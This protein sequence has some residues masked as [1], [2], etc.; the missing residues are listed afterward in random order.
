VI[1]EGKM[2]EVHVRVGVPEDFPALMVLAEEVAKENGVA[3]PDFDKVAAEMWASLHQDLG[4]VGVVGEPGGRLEAFVLLII[5]Q[6]WYSADPI[7]E[8]R[9]VFVSKDYRSAKG[10]RARKLCEFS[11]RVSE[12]LGLGLLIG[13]LSNQRTQAKVELYKRVFGEP[14][15]A[16]WLHNANTGDWAKQAAE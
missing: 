9:T 16:F 6:T 4:I 2:S 7:I 3:Q 12:E 15:G 14:A 1:E 11:K 5:G 10:G 13:I 8:E